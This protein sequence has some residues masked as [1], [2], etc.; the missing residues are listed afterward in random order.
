V[1]G[2]YIVHTNKMIRQDDC[3]RRSL[4]RQTQFAFSRLLFCVYLTLFSGFITLT[5]Y[6]QGLNSA[7]G[8]PNKPVRI[9]AGFPPGQATD[10]LTRMIAVELSKTFD[11]QFFVD[12][13]PGA[14][15]IIATQM[16]TKADPDGYTLIGTSSGP[17]AVNPSLYSKLPYDVNRDLAMVCGSWGCSLCSSG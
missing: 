6:A 15:G 16:L 12:N 13:K 3:S 9:L 17:L 7:Q 11:Q 4:V 5:A 1:W 8:Y 2:K 10:V 14:A